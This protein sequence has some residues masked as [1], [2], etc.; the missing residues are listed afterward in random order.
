VHAWVNTFFVGTGSLVYR[1]H[2]ADWGNRT[3][4]GSSAGYLDPGVPE[5]QIYTHKVLIDIA[6]RYDIDGLHLDFIRYPGSDWGYSP[7]A[8]ALYMLQTG[9]TAVPAAD[10]PAWQEW[11]RARVTAFVRDLHQ[12]L[13]AQKPSVK[14][15]GALICYGGAPADAAGWTS[16]SAYGSVYQDW[17]DWLVKGYLDIGVPMN[18]DSD[19]SNREKGWF[20]QWLAFEKDSGFAGHVITGVGVFL[21][22]PEQSLSQIRRALAPSARGN[23]VL[24]VAIYSYASTSVYGTDDFYGSTDLSGSLPRQPYADGIS[25]QYGLASRAAI[26]N[27]WFILQLTQPGSYHDVQLGWITTQPVFAQPA[28]VPTLAAGA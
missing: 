24:G 22:Y 27:A 6:R 1:Q 15:S 28:M 10:D 2:G 9:A 11:R 21:N 18:Y 14:L 8:T 3:S 4:D 20:D 23:H 7:V 17:R 16:T 25:D 13:Q 19:W 5:V 26:F 12:D